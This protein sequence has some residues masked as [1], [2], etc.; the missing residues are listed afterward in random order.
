MKYEWLPFKSF[1]PVEIEQA[2]D[3]ISAEFGS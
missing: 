2:I 1:T 3:E